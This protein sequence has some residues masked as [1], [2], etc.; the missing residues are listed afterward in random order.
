MWTVYIQLTGVV[1][2]EPYARPP[3]PYERLFSG[4]WEWH[5]E[6]ELFRNAL[7]DYLP[8]LV[9][10]PLD[11]A[12]PGDFI[13]TGRPGQP[14]NHVAVLLPGNMLLHARM[15]PRRLTYGGTLMRERLTP[16]FLKTVR[17]ALTLY[18]AEETVCP[19]V[20]TS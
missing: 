2:W 13:L 4:E 14:S 9:D 6:D 3:A 10:I 12:Q 20:M 16:A 1:P 15:D 8:A 5:V 11:Q 18:V 17:G 7:R 19:A